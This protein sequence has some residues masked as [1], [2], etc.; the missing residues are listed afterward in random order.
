[1]KSKIKVVKQ[2]ATRKL[3]KTKSNEG[4]KSSNTLKREIIPC[5]V[6]NYEENLYG[7]G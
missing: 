6:V 2:Q 1:M 7:K 3:R 4:E 5:G